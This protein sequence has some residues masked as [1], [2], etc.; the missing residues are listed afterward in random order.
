MPP[1]PLHLLPVDT[2]LA[3]IRGSVGSQA[4]R[5][6]YAI[7]NNKKTNIVEDGALSCAFFVSHILLWFQLIHE[8][9]ARV[10]GT[11]HD[12]KASGWVLT[13]TPKEGDILVWDI[14]K[15]HAHI[16]FFLGE[17]RAISNSSKLKYPQ[18][19]HWT[20]GTHDDGTPVRALTAVYTHPKF[21]G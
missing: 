20:F 19:H 15:E 1:S 11:L 16:G 7:I 17:D 3:M 2:Y 12:M 13:R 6:M 8:P 21:F 4:Y 18:E 5:S 14:A 9:H 10:A